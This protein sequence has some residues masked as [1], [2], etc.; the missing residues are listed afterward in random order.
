M[1]V[2]RVFAELV[3]HSP[4]LLIFYLEKLEKQ[5]QD[6]KNTEKTNEEETETGREEIN[7]KRNENLTIK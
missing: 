1:M 2:D 6:N 7:H 5:F 3:K 4:F